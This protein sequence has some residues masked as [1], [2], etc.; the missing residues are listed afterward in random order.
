MHKPFD[1][2][3][4]LEEGKYILP[5]YSNKMDPKFL[6]NKKSVPWLSKLSFIHLKICFTGNNILDNMKIY[7]SL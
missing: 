4:L 7:Q 6:M 2:N 3:Y 5:F 1:D